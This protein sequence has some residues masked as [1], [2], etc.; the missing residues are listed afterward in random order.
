MN[1]S[2]KLMLFMLKKVFKYNCLDCKRYWSNEEIVMH[3]QN[4]LC[5]E[6]QTAENTIEKLKII[7]EKRRQP[8]ENKL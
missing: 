7:S 2:N 6:D 1:D 3:K 4:N 5:V 8:E